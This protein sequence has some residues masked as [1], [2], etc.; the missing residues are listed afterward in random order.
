MFVVVVVGEEIVVVE[1]EEEEEG[2]EVLLLFAVVVL[3]LRLRV[4]RFKAKS[5]NSLASEAVI[6][7]TPNEATN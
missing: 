7:Y 3:L 5:N 4:R 2:E 6:S 1:G